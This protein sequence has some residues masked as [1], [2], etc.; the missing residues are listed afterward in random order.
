MASGLTCEVL[1]RYLALYITG[2]R[3][4]KVELDRSV[5][6]STLKVTTSERLQRTAVDAE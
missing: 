3:R 1:F 4:K 6:L 2:V 5:A